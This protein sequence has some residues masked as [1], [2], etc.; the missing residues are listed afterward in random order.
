MKSALITI[1]ESGFIG[2]DKSALIAR[3]LLLANRWLWL[4]L[5]LWP[6]VMAAILRLGSGGVP[7]QHD[8]L[9][10][11]DVLALLQQE[12]LYGL[13]LVAFTG[14]AL[15][16]NEQRSRRIVVVLARAVGRGEYLFALW[17]TT[18][19]PLLLYMASVTL[20]GRLLGATGAVLWRF[21]VA[22]MLLGI[23]LACLTLLWS[24]WVPG[25]VASTLSLALMAGLLVLPGP[26]HMA[27][28]MQLRLLVD[29]GMPRGTLA[30]AV[31]SVCAGAVIFAAA[32]LIFRRR[33]LDLKGD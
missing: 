17:L 3:R 27:L 13:A 25:V 32:V 21:G 12:C 9:A 6:W 29:G 4:L 19:L 7:T 16:G 33:D 15:L 11:Q 24:I 18:V 8:F 31:E 2:L 20:A 30:A 26:A 22:G 28:A 5:V 23:P 10:Q 1:Q 14:G